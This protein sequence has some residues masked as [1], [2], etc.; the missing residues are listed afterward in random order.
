MK[1][2]SIDLETS[3]LDPKEHQILEFGAVI[4]DTDNPCPIENLPSFHVYLQW[5]NICGEPY[6]LAL[7]HKILS[8]ISDNKQW[9]DNKVI[10]PEDLGLTFGA[11]I[12]DN[13]QNDSEYSG[14]ITVAG[15]NFGNFDNQFLKNYSKYFFFTHV[16][17]E[18]RFLDPGSIFFDPTID[19]K[20][21]GLDICL[22]RV[23]INKKINHTAV[24]DAQD[25]IRALR[26]KLK[27]HDGK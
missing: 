2:V 14:K 24:E 20:L 8:L 25:V 4:E 17:F 18:H 16:A 19:K 1:Y 21:P 13:F 26:G 23:G 27:Y 5:K 6:A 3:G 12:K 11:F 15:K 22:E 10:F 7:N 9:K